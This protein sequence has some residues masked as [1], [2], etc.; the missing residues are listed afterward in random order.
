AR[1]RPKR[2]TQPPHAPLAR[3]T[4]GDANNW[5]GHISSDSRL[6]IAEFSLGCCVLATAAGLVGASMQQ[7]G[8]LSDRDLDRPM[9]AQRPF[10]RIV[11][12]KPGLGEAIERQC[13]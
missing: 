1:P 12:P 9:L 8:T 6:W 7:F 13:G 2:R 10:L 4:V 5:S 3:L 11:R